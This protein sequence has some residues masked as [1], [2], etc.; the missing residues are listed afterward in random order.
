MTH[1]CKTPNQIFRCLDISSGFDRGCC[2]SLHSTNDCPP[3]TRS[4]SVE[5]GIP[6]GVLH[7]P[8][9][10][11]LIASATNASTLTRFRLLGR[12]MIGSGVKNFQLVGGAYENSHS[13]ETPLARK[14][15]YYG[16]TPSTKTPLVLE[17]PP[18]TEK[19]LVRKQLEYGNTPSTET[20]P[21]VWKHP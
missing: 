13:T 7:R 8:W 17:T 6:R 14:H 11:P 4:S 5:R 3:C 1:C 16:N 20:P 2:V 18:S 9:A 10:M 12:C 21:L 15:P 19:P